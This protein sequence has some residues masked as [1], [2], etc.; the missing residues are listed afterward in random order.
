MHV[1]LAPRGGTAPPIFAHPHGLNKP[2]APELLTHACLRVRL[3]VW[4][5][6]MRSLAFFLILLLFIPLPVL[7]QQNQPGEP[8]ISAPRSGDAVQG[9]VQLIGTSDIPGFASAEV[10]FGY[11]DDPTGTWFQIS[12]STLPVTEGILATWDT[13]GITDGN[14]VLRLRVTLTDGTTRDAFAT[15]LRVRNYSPI[16]TPTPLPTEPQPTLTPTITLT[17]TLWPTPTPLDPNPAVV[18]TGE[19]SISILYGGL[20]AVLIFIILG[21]YLWLRWRR[22]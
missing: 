6:Y 13:N 8:V 20:A 18:S 21:S 10:A 9:L 1:S 11:M 3:N 5:F 17:P 2:D 19:L 4:P 22:K 12:R 14:Y 7:A 16:E 15:S